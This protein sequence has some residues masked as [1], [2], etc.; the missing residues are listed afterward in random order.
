MARVTD[1]AVVMVEAMID[2]IKAD[3]TTPPTRP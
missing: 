2:L 1:S 3:I